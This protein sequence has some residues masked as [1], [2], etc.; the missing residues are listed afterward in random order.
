MSHASVFSVARLPA[1]WLLFA[2]CANLDS[3]QFAMN[4][5]P[6]PTGTHEEPGT[7]SVQRFSLTFYYTVV[8]SVMK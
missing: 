3:N 5:R 4:R 8:V 2:V 1:R 7:R 6:I